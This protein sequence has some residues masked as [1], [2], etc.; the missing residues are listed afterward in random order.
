MSLHLLLDMFLA[1]GLI[2]ELLGLVYIVRVERE[3]VADLRP[4]IEV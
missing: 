3:V 4:T 2:I 1:I